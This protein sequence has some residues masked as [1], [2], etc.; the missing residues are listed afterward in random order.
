MIVLRSGEDAGED[1]GRMD[2]Y[3]ALLVL[4]ALYVNGAVRRRGC[5]CCAQSSREYCAHPP[6][7]AVLRPPSTLRFET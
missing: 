1:G 7:R 6:A 4:A 3:P 5:S 2:D